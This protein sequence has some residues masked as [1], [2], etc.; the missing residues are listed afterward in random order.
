[1]Q[2]IE[3]NLQLSEHL[4]KY[5]LKE[6]KTKKMIKHSLLNKFVYKQNNIEAMVKSTILFYSTSIFIKNCNIDN[7]NKNQKIYYFNSSFIK[8]K[9]NKDTFILSILIDTNLNIRIELNFNSLDEIENF[10]ISN[11]LKDTNFENY[12]VNFALNNSLD[13]DYSLY[14]ITKFYK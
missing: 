12:N 10:I 5:H 13:F 3:Y 8:V 4:K 1:M 2:K 7:S 6:Y 9:Q 11:F 14:S